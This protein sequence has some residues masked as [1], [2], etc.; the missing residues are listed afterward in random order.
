MG[1]K[2]LVFSD[3][4]ATDGHERC[5]T[6][7]NTPLQLYRVTK[8]YEDLWNI[9]KANRCECLWD[10]GDTTDDRSSIPIPALEAVIAGLEPFPEHELNIKLIGNHEQYLRDTTVNAGR[11]FRSKFAVVEKTEVFEAANGVLIAAAAFPASD[12]SATAWLDETAYAY[13]NYEQR[14]LL[15]HFQVAGCQL[16]SGQALLGVP[17][18][19]VEKYSLALLGHVHKPQKVGLNSFY[20]GSP[21]QQNFGE[22]NEVKRVAIVDLETLQVTWVPLPGYPEYHVL[23][24]ATWAHRVKSSEEH[25]Y[26]VILRTVADAENFYKHP[27]MAQAEPVYNY[28]A[29]VGVTSEVAANQSWTLNAVLKRWLTTVPPVVSGIELPDSDVL[30]IGLALADNGSD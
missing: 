12:A 20:V 24:Y 2:A 18:T 10:L 13:R 27:L 29:P 6:K 9:F 16:S 3:L 30:D 21:F 1:L 14:I 23:D 5:F 11:M 7:A 15:G 25:R 19:A 17:R 28:D 22:R 8:F 26:Q 4:Q